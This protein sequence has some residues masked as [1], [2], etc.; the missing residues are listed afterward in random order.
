MDHV[1][2]APHHPQ[3]QG[4]IERWHQ[5]LNHRISAR[6]IR[7]LTALLTASIGAGFVSEHARVEHLFGLYERMRAP[8]AASKKNRVR[9][10]R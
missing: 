6:R 2:G 4:K 8:Q 10:K 9:R 3:T 1:S 7:R 5:T